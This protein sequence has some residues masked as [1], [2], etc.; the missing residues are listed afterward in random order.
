MINVIKVDDFEKF[1]AKLE[2]I[3]TAI[4]NMP[5]PTGSD[6]EEIELTPGDGTTSRTY[7]FLRTPKKISMQ[8]VAEGWGFYRDIIW[9]SD[10][11]FYQ[12]SQYRTSD[13]VTY[14]GVSSLEY[15][16][17]EIT[18]TGLNAIQASNSADIVGKMLVFY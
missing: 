11:S 10:R 18:I 4:Q 13:S 15:N 12:A 5:T 8:Y 17:N 14:V 2:E 7:S 9:G 6:I 16:D 1:T 3:A